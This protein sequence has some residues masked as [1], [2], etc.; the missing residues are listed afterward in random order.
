[1]ITLGQAE[2]DNINRMIIITEDCCLGVK[3]VIIEKDVL[4]V[5]TQLFIAKTNN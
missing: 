4:L 2:S 5:G 3:G 1:M